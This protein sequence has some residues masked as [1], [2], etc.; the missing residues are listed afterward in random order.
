MKWYPLESNPASL[1]SYVG[2]LG[3]CTDLFALHDVLSI[4]SWATSMIPKPVLAVVF[5]YPLTTTQ[6]DHRKKE[7]VA[8]TVKEA[9]EKGV[10]FTK[11]RI[12]N[13]C[14]TIGA[15]HALANI[16]R[17]FIIRGSWMDSFL[18]MSAYSVFGEECDDVFVKRAELLEGDK[19]VSVLHERAT[20]NHENSTNRGNI[21]D[22][23]LTHF[24]TFTVVGGIL[25]ELDG[26][27]DGPIPHGP[28][29]EE[30]LLDD[31]CAA[32]K[33]FMDRAD[34]GELRFTILA[35]AGK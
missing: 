16:D 18:Q 34:P 27:K 8:L 11:Q 13:A 26:R 17:N 20:S 31:S 28:S 12:G 4:E 6:E 14:G 25:Y 1:T 24:I 30:S 32:I 19:A 21:D 22:K 35:L 3:L 5:L 2:E 33:R 9:R 15:L 7:K 10:W 23:V 29:S